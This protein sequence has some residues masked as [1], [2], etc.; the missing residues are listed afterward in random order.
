MIR[1]TIEMIQK[2]MSTNKI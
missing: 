2:E 1:I